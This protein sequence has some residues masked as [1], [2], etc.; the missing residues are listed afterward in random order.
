M[1]RKANKFNSKRFQEQGAA[2]EIDLNFQME[3]IANDNKLKQDSLQQ[4]S[5]TSKN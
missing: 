1:Q 4:S 5:T 3:K 2:F